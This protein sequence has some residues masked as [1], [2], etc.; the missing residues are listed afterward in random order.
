MD[1]ITHQVC[2][3]HWTKIIYECINRGASRTAWCRAKENSEKQFFYWPKI[4]P[5]EA[6]DNYQDSLLP[7]TVGTN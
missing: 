6:F 5:G 4:L 2:A 7:T 1:K 3:E